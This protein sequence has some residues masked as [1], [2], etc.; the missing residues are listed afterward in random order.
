MTT[1]L[2]REAPFRPPRRPPHQLVTTVAGR[3]ERPLSHSSTHLVHRH[4]GERLLVGVDPDHHHANPPSRRLHGCVG[5][6]ASI[7]TDQAPIKSLRPGPD[8]PH[9]AANSHHPRW[10]TEETSEPAEIG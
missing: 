7:Q 1:I 3:L 5:G 10:G 9:I 6:H 2:H 8:G 4:C